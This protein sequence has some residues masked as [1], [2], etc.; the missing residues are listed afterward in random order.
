VEEERPESLSPVT[1][2][3]TTA[4]TTLKLDIGIMDDEIRAEMAGLQEQ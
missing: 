1:P 3:K 4:D 2:S